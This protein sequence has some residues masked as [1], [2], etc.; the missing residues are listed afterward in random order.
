MRYSSF[1]VKR[2]IVGRLETGEDLLKSLGKI[3]MDEGI[4]SGLINLIGALKRFRL[5]FFDPETGEYSTIE[6]DGLYELISCIGNISWKDGEP[7]VHIHLV[8]STEEKVIGGHVLEGC[9][10]GP[11]VEFSIF[12]LDRPI[13]K[14]YFEDSKL[15]L[16]DL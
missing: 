9:I 16:F 12:E 10:V 1:N 14:R 8:L 7:I 2:I 4:T 15:N 6:G 3:A 5:G 13:Y 11:T